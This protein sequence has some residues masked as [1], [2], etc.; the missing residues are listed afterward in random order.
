MPAAAR[1]ALRLQRPSSVLGVLLI[2]ALGVCLLATPVRAQMPDLRQMAGQPLPSGDLA[3]GSVSVRVVRQ[4]ISNNLSGVAVAVVSEPSAPGGAVPR[5][6]TDQGGRAVFQGLTPGSSY[7]VTAVVD[8]EALASQPFI[9]PPTGGL[10]IL[11]VAGLNAGSGTSAPSAVPAVPAKPG[12]ITLGGQSRFVFEL[13]EGSVEVFSL[14]DVINPT[15]TPVSLATPLVFELPREAVNASLLDGSTPLARVDGTRVVLNGPLPAG[16]TNVQFAY[17]M[18][19]DAA[20]LS[21]RQTL[22]LSAPQATVIVRKFGELSAALAGEQARREATIEGRT[23]IV[24]NTAPITANA[25]L[26]VTLAGL[27]AHPRWPRLLALGLALLI[28]LGGAWLAATT[29][30][31]LADES[32]SLSADRVARFDELL[33]VQRSLTREPTPELEARRAA[34]ISAIAEIDL[35]LQVSEPG[36]R[37]IVTEGADGKIDPR[38]RTSAAQ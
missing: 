30:Q 19:T 3:T 4:A 17:R 16:S 10:R 6:T 14:L 33:E 7:R 31:P 5:G 15:G 2:A 38:A 36:Q 12:A 18:P 23:Y 1:R 13:A 37:S 27:P 8:G 11:L 24:L 28:A 22:P 21:V 25:A 29:R 35:A 9:V 34:L 32:E 26:Q 20:T